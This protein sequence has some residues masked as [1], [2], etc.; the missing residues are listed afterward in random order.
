MPLK[1]RKFIRTA[2]GEGHV[3]ELTLAEGWVIEPMEATR[4]PLWIYGAGHVGRALVHT[5]HPLPNVAITWVDTGPERFPDAVPVG[6][7]AM[8]SV[9]PARAAGHAPEEAVHLVL[10]YSHALDLALCH[11]L[12]ARPAAGIG[13]IGS[14]TKWAR[15]RSRLRQ[16]GHS[17]AQISRI[18]CPIGDPGLGKHPQAIAVGVASSLLSGQMLQSSAYTAPSAA[19]AR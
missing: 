8:P 9:D 15:F 2:R 4:R 14:A 5:L 3:P 12:L 11:A 13:L 1:I 7:T 6:V 17:D 16:L 19:Q 10:T 18:T